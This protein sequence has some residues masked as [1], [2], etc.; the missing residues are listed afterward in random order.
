MVRD[1]RES[2]PAS[3]EGPNI[4]RIF[5]PSTDAIL[6]KT[7]GLGSSPLPPNGRLNGCTSWWTEA[8]PTLFCSGGSYKPRRPR[9]GW[10]ENDKVLQ[11]P[12]AFQYSSNSRPDAG[13]GNP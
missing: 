11:R 12:K 10:H 1:V 3:D 2:G 5:F 7:L 4:L 8:F 9:A 6:Q 13:T